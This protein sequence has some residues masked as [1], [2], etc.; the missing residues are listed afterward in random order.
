MA[1]TLT[2]ATA[3]RAVAAEPQAEITSSEGQS[4]STQPPLAFI[5]MPFDAEF[6]DVYADLIQTPLESAGFQ[7]RRADSLLNQRSVLQD[8]VRGIADA[9]L[10]VADVSGLNPNVMYELG[11]AHALGKRTIM[12]TRDIDE[13]PFDLRP[14]RANPYS[15]RFTEAGQ[16]V[17]TLE[18]IGKAVLAGTAQFSNPVQD[19]APDA[20]TASSQVSVSL[21]A[22][23]PSDERSESGLAGG[24]D[25][26][27]QESEPGVFEY[28]QQLHDG[29]EHT[30]EVM[31]R[32]S[33]ATEEIGRQ[34]QGHTE[35][36]E[37]AQKNLGNKGAGVYL[38]ITRDSAK[39]INNFS[40]TLA[41][42]NRDLR[43]SIMSFADA[44]TGL[45]RNR[46][47]ESDEDRQA[48]AEDIRAIAEAED[49]VVQS[50]FSVVNFANTLLELPNMD[51]VLT[52]AARRAATLVSETAEI[53][54]SAQAEYARARGL[55]EERAREARS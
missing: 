8:V 35:R 25:D 38:S 15:V 28:A 39:D 24:A 41:P 30:V 53:M 12:I 36:L 23:E 42:A 7:V 48:V 3:Q 47:V 34:I 9:A 21:N 45:A 1:L 26:D 37:R 52:Q 46:V 10:I 44:A 55:L 18:E 2:P 6:A 13:L 20:L 50:Y 51:R 32:I 49:A 22:R 43:Q 14:Y 4:M 31:T 16:I 33:S 19:F 5:L 29:S 40:E 27:D 17:A 54:E 11:L